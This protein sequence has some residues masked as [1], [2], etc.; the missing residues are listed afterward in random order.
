M[1]GRLPDFR[2]MSDFNNAILDAGI[3]EFS[4]MGSKYTW[5]NNHDPS[6]RMWCQLDRVFLYSHLAS[7]F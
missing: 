4:F 1:G 7:R 3:Q 5:S 2:G 6:S